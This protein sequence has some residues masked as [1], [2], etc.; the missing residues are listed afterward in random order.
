MLCILRQ[1]GDG[2][3]KLLDGGEKEK[4]LQNNVDERISTKNQ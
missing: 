4:K 1:L 3:K 2:E